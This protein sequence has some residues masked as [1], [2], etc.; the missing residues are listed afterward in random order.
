MNA[1]IFGSAIELLTGFSGICPGVSAPRSGISD[2]P[3]SA[4]RHSDAYGSPDQGRSLASR[5]VRAAAGEEGACSRANCYAGGAQQRRGCYHSGSGAENQSRS[6]GGRDGVFDRR[7][8]CVP[9]EKPRSGGVSG[10]SLGGPNATLAQAG[11]SRGFLGRSAVPTSLLGAN[12]RVL[13]AF[14]NNRDQVLIAHFRVDVPARQIDALRRLAVAAI[15]IALAA[16]TR[17]EGGAFLSRMML[18]SVSMAAGERSRVRAF[19]LSGSRGR[20]P[21]L[22]LCPFANGIVFALF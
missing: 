5:V 3:K 8:E 14:L 7:F 20:P 10:A 11:E 13:S 17:A 6:S 22:P 4:E 2:T 18:A 1:F 19:T 12:E 16:D 21:G 15:Q 9:N